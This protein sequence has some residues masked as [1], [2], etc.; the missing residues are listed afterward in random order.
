MFWDDEHSEKISQ[1]KKAPTWNIESFLS[2]SASYS[3]IPSKKWIKRTSNDVAYVFHTSGTSSGS[4]KPIFQRHQAAVGVLPHLSNQGATF[5]TTP[6]YHGGIADCFRT[7]T[8]GAAIWCFPEGIMPITATNIIL[9][10][11]YVAVL[12]TYPVQYFTSVPYILQMMSKD[13]EALMRLGEMKMVGVGGAALP[14]SI[15]DSLV[16]RGVKLVSRFGSAECGF[17]MSSYRDF[18]NDQDWTFLRSDDSETYLSF[19]DRDEGL[20]ELVISPSWPCLSISN[21]EDG[22]YATADLFEPHPSLENS[23]KYHSRFDSQIVLSTGK[24]FDTSPI[25]DA[26]VSQ[27]QCLQGM[28]VF[29]TD[30]P[31]PGALLFPHNPVSSETGVIEDVWKVLQPMN[32]H[33]QIHSRLSKSSLVVIEHHQDEAPLPKSSKGTVLR[34]QAEQLYQKQILSIYES[35]NSVERKRIESNT[36]PVNDVDILKATSDAVT[37]TMGRQVDI[38]QDLYEQ[39]V[40][41]VA[42]A[43]IRGILNTTIASTKQSDLPMNVVYDCGSVRSLAH[44]MS[45]YGKETDMSPQLPSLPQQPSLP[46]NH[47]LM[48]DYVRKYGRFRSLRPLNTQASDTDGK[49]VL[50]TGPTGMLGSHILHCLR[51]DTSITKVYCLVRAK[52]AFEAYERVSMALVV[53]EMD[54]LPPYNDMIAGN[55]KVVCFPCDLAREDLG[56]SKD[57][58][59]EIV[60]KL[61]TV[62]HSAWSV[63]FSLKLESFALQFAGTQNLINLAIQSEASFFFVSSTAA[64]CSSSE[65]PIEEQ[66]APAPE[67]ASPLGYSQ[68]KW[69]G[70]WI[71]FKAHKRRIRTNQGCSSFS[72]SVIRVGQLCGNRNGIWNMHEAFPLILSSAKYTK[73]LPSLDERLSW[74]PVDQAAK[75]ILEIV[76]SKR[77]KSS[78]SIGPAVYH[79]LNPHI[80]PVWKDL[81]NT[82]QRHLKPFTFKIVEPRVWL[83]T[84]KALLNSRVRI[85]QHQRLSALLPL[86]ERAYGSDSG[87]SDTGGQRLILFDVQKTVST[88]PM[89]A[90]V[91]PLQSQELLKM[92]TWIQ[93]Q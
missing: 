52:T 41:S 38:D 89:M 65:S 18:R 85:A 24:K 77:D 1:Y 33:F 62:I 87:Q 63:N 56:I 32:E 26:V 36:A 80:Q 86:W 44:F 42:C 22:S 46:N 81:L 19:E 4:P 40:D 49:H 31:Y 64:V 68:S 47:I 58:I 12:T 69:V 82:C 91:Q 93:S 73:C 34:S 88:S 28:L 78:P 25:E 70:E 60:P 83:D 15:G 61:T 55:N 21:R 6:L 7:W 71:C 74:L 90:N 13:K 54:A 79:V 75:S 30:K 9:C 45:K 67:S 76:V 37:R 17:L 72:T 27:V 35:A 2:N 57:D 16:A 29:G 51:D 48:Q 11:D 59:Q 10:M 23:W 53:G 3:D 92:W 8:S 5:T 14:Q 50:L 43:Q 20:S 84:L 39:G 66:L